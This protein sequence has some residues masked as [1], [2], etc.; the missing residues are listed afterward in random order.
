MVQILILATQIS[1]GKIQNIKV[2]FCLPPHCAQWAERQK[3]ETK[4]SEK[5]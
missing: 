4:T 1:W 5:S 3:T 2:I